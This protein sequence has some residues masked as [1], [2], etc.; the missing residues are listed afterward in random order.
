ME[1]SDLE[2]SMPIAVFFPFLLRLAGPIAFLGAAIVAGVMNRSFVLVPLLAIA[3][4]LVTILIRRF[5]PSPALN[6]Q[7]MISPEAQPAKPDLFKGL[8]P[9]FGIGLVGYAIAFGLAASIAALF[10][11]TEF[12]PRVLASD[13]WFAAIPAV[14]A[15][16]GAWLSARLGLNQMAS[17]M[18]E[19]QGMFAQMQAGQAPSAANDDEAFT[20]EGEIINPD[21]PR[22]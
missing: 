16:A 11:S 21:E 14:L 18:G 20:V 19:M 8:I 1:G 22:S 4:T 7:A 10:Q 5:T 13:I 9:R 15:I 6:L 12:E 2:P 3:A 17:M